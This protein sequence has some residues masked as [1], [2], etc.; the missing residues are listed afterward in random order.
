MLLRWLTVLAVVF[1]MIFTLNGLG[2]GLRFSHVLAGDKAKSAASERQEK[3]KKNGLA[4]VL[5]LDAETALEATP[6]PDAKKQGK[7]ADAPGRAHA[8]KSGGSIPE[9]PATPEPPTPARSEAPPVVKVPPGQAKKAAEGA[10]AEQ[11]LGAGTAAADAAGAAGSGVAL[12]AGADG[13]GDCVTDPP[14]PSTEPEI[15]P[16]NPPLC[17]GGYKVESPCNG[18]HTYHYTVEGQTVTITIDVYDTANGQAFNWTSSWPVERVV[19]KGGS[20]GAN[21]YSYDPAASSDGGLHAPQAN[22]NN[23]HWAGLSYIA[24]CFGEKPPCE[25]TKTFEVVYPDLPDGARLWVKYQVDDGD[26]KTEELVASG[27]GVYTFVDAHIPEGALVKGQWLLTHGDETEVL[28]EFEEVL[29]EDTTNHF[30][31]KPDVGGSKYEDLNGNGTRDEGEPGIGGWGIT[32]YRKAWLICDLGTWEEFATVHTNPDGTYSFPGLP[33]GMYKVTEEE[34]E[35]WKQTDAPDPA[36]FEIGPCSEGVG[37]LDFGN[38]ELPDVTVL[39]FNDY[40]GNGVQDLIGGDVMEPA[41]PGWT[42]TLT[43][44]DGVPVEKITGE[45]GTATW[46]DL[47]LGSYVL[48]EA[49]R[50]G[51]KPIT[52]LPLIVDLTMSGED[53]AVTVGNQMITTPGNVDLAI[54]KAANPTTVAPGAMVTYRLTYSNLGDAPATDFTIVDDYDQNLVAEVVNAGG[55]I[56]DTAAGTITWKFAGPL[57]KEDGPKSVVYTVKI[58]ATID[59]DTFVDNVAVISDP[60]DTNPSNNKD[61]ARVKVVVEPMLPYTEPEESL[62]FTGGDFTIIAMLAA[63]S[64]AGG[65]ALRRAGRGELGG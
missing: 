2:F 32:L 33:P 62:P 21:V 12:F 65:L 53:K 63:F 60:K 55:G 54:I 14:T 49:E 25:I 51:W 45:D 5:G 35:G 10:A 42:F 26:Y 29:C 24:F 64:M 58:K 59:K 28:G 46:A 52:E 15:V 43:G 47:E 9:T 31:Y 57:A 19:V 48:D 13:S 56:V 20:L 40:N 30:E 37:P 39:K 34:R 1:A 50:E 4:G 17:E 7:D 6:T 8:D 16:G 38:L 27:D 18:S 41:I 11:G 23:P 61:D 3:A 36:E 44:S 22:E